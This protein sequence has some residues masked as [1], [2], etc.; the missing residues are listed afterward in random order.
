[1]KIVVPSAKDIATLVGGAPNAPLLPL[2]LPQGPPAQPGQQPPA[3]RPL[4]EIDTSNFGPSD[5]T[6]SSNEI[7]FS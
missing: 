1:M 7:L 3:P 2:P 6:L 5:T 4:L